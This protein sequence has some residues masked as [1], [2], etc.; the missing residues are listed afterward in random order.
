MALHRADALDAAGLNVIEYSAFAPS[1]RPLFF[2]AAHHDMVPSGRARLPH[3]HTTD[4]Q[5]TRMA[6]ESFRETLRAT[7]RRGRSTRWY[8]R[9]DI[10][11]L[12][13]C[14]RGYAWTGSRLDVAAGILSSTILAHPFP[15]ANHRTSVALARMYLAAAGVPW[16]AYEIRGRGADRFFRETHGF[17]RESKY[18][19]Q[20]LR[21]RHLV[22][23]AHE[24][25]YTDLHIG[26]DTDAPIRPRDLDLDGVGIRRRHRQISREVLAAL[27]GPEGRRG[28]E[29]QNSLGLEAWVRW[30]QR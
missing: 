26:V 21:H 15:N 30:Y 22:R 16:P 5:A 4:W 9:L 28:I 7:R 25:G 3:A 18:L 19:L 23:V 10:E 20:L 27:A 1:G 12:H 11:A 8:K 29:E 17:Y 14:V 6:V 24:E 13:G 2:V